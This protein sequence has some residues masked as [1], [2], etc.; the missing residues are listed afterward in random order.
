MARIKDEYVQQAREVPIHEIWSRL[1]LPPV[2]PGA[3]VCS[4]FR[5]D[6]KPSCQVGGAK[7]IVFDYGSTEERLDTIALVRKVRGVNFKDAV[8]FVLGRSFE[9]LIEQPQVAQTPKKSG[10]RS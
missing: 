7:N 4:P 10:E 1:G 9:S 2:R 8:A 3:N 5:E 6:S